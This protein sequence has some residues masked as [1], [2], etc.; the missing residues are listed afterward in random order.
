MAQFAVSEGDADGV[1]EG[2]EATLDEA[3]LLGGER[4]RRRECR[5]MVPVAAKLAMVLELLGL[6]E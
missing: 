4:C 1:E 5:G 6:S 3:V 2:A